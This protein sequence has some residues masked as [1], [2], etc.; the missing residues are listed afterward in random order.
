MKISEISIKR[1]VFAT[2]MIA[3][4]LVVGAFSYYE[5]PVELMPDV[6]FPFVIVQTVYPG[7]SAESVETDVTKDIEE[8]INEI[9]RVRHIESR[10]REGYSLV[11]VEFELEKDGAQAAQ[12]VREKVAAVRG[13]LPDDIEEPIITQYD[14]DAFPILS[15]AIT[16]SRP[17]RDITE[18]AKN[19]IKPRIEV[20]NGVGNVEIVGGFDRE[21]L[22]ALNPEK[23][24]SYGVSI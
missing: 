24:E 18:L 13:E 3:A 5:L 8:V 14:H 20:I 6:D 7:A 11:M 10:S 21:I 15:L 4:L 23:M 19:R 16:G 12:D 17:L 9:S 22:V 1:P 2:M